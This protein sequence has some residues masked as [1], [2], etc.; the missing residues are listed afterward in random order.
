MRVLHSAT[1]ALALATA[2][3]AAQSQVVTRQIDNEPV[4]TTVVQTPDGTVI[5][6]RPLA[7]APVESVA[8]AYGG[9]PPPAYRAAPAVASETYVDESVGAASSARIIRR[10]AATHTT[11]RTETRRVHAAAPADRVVTGHA[12]SHVVRHATRRIAAVPA[13]ALSAAQRRVVYRT[14]VQEQVVP[15]APAGYPPYPAPAYRPRAVVAPGAVTTGYAVN[16]SEDVADVYA[17]PAPPA[18]APLRYTVGSVLPAEVAITPLP[19]PAVVEVPSL[20]PYRYA[21]IDG[22]VLLV[23][24]ATNAVVADITP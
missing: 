13:L 3:G 2:S 8:P 12:T 15:A 23:D 20:Q 9:Y 24:P 5:T 1:L 14:I 16:T 21:T 7:A 11:V 4:E 6:R 17:E 19:A 18:V 10:S 22:R